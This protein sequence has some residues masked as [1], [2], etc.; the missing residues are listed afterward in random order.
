MYLK[1][2]V[3]GEK[4]ERIDGQ[5]NHKTLVVILYRHHHNGHGYLCQSRNS[6]GTCSTG[7]SPMPGMWKRSQ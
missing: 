2:R 3:Y 5:K 7:L 4:G 1:N 6:D